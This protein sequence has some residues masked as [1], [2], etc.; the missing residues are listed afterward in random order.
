MLFLQAGAK[1]LEIRCC[2]LYLNVFCYL[3]IP[4]YQQIKLNIYSVTNVWNV[5]LKNQK[6]NLVKI[7]VLNT[8]IK[9]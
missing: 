7:N 8:E 9:Y 4:F 6:L 2:T 3:I 5:L 1:N